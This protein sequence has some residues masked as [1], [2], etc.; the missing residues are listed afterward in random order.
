MP[1]SLAKLVVHLIFSTKGRRPLIPKE[2]QPDLNSYLAG[3]LRNLNSPAII[4]ASLPDH[5]HL[6]FNLHREQAVS[7]VVMKLKANSSLWMKKQNPDFNFFSWQNGYGAFSVSESRV[8][9]VKD[10]INRQHEHHKKVSFQE[11]LKNFL[12]K[13]HIEYDERYLWD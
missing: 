8:A 12:E 5:V 7:R 1:Q 2:R 9:I 4:I 10:Y 11:E 13:H 3:I 6:L